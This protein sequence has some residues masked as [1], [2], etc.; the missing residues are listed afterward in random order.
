MRNFAAVICL[1]LFIP[2]SAVAGV[3]RDI[4]VRKVQSLLT[5][6][7]YS[8]GPIDGAWGRKTETAA[9]KFFKD[10]KFKYDGRLGND[11]F[12]FLTTQAAFSNK[13]CTR[14]QNKTNSSTNNEVTNSRLR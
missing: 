5:K 6:L 11:Q 4:D 9:K 12:S 8:P 1:I 13:K 7:C 3:D 10:Y 2:F 14:N